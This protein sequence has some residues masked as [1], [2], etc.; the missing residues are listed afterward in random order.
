[1]SIVVLR[2]TPCKLLSKSVMT[3]AKANLTDGDAATIYNATMSVVLRVGKATAAGIGECRG[4]DNTMCG[5][6]A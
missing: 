1:M 5:R 6:P 4:V 2:R 3:I